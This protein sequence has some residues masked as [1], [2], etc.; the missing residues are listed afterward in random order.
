VETGVAAEPLEQHMIALG[1]VLDATQQ[2]H[3]RVA[4]QIIVE[5]HGVQVLD[6]DPAEDRAGL[7]NVRGAAAN[8]LAH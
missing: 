7:L 5:V 6:R 3:G 1:A 4:P 2:T 8:Q